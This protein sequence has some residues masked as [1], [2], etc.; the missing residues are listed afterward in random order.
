MS[1]K[2]IIDAVKLPTL[3]RTLLNIIE[4]EKLNPISFLDDIKKIVEKDPLL[5]AHLLQV[6]NSPFYGFTQKVR[7]ISHAIGLLGVRKIKT[8]AFSFSIFDFLKNIDYKTGYG[9]TFNLILKKS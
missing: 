6:A 3:S 1:S 7:T 9:G 4:V 8:M 2:K 5:S